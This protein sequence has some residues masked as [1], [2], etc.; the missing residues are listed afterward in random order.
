MSDVGIPG[1]DDDGDAD[2]HADLLF[3]LNVS[4]NFN[5]FESSINIEIQF[6]M[7]VSANL[8]TFAL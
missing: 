5:V 8:S 4:A 2:G 1:R 7:N 3:L 6:L